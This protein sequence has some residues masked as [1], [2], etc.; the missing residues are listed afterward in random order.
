MMKYLYYADE[1]I[2]HTLNYNML[3][4]IRGCYNYN[5]S[6]RNIRSRILC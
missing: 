3:I 5:Q 2:T 1:T 4:S 6:G